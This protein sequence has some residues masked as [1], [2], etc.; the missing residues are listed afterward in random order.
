MEAPRL[1]DPD[2]CQSDLVS[3]SFSIGRARWNPLFG[4]SALRVIALRLGMAAIWPVRIA[5]VRLPDHQFRRPQKGDKP[6]AD[7]FGFFSARYSSPF[8]FRQKWSFSGSR[9]FPH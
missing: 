3:I 2:A 8:H 5:Q 4:I 9:A 7:S 1:L 6:C